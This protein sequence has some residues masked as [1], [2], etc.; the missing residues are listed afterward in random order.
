MSNFAVSANS[1][2]SAV[3]SRTRWC[4]SS[5]VSVNSHVLQFYLSTD[6]LMFDVPMLFVFAHLRYQYISQ[7]QSISDII[8][9]NREYE[10][11]KIPCVHSSLTDCWK[12]IQLIQIYFWLNAICILQRFCLLQYSSVC[13]FEK[14]NPKVFTKF[15]CPRF[16]IN[17]QYSSPEITLVASIFAE[18]LGH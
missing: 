10:N 18:V 4:V 12:T 9:Y 6:I 17:V 5:P 11:A 3:S 1:L 7:S 13:C 16:D 14:K 15:Y 8:L 2:C